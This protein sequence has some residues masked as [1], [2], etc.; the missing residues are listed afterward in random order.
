MAVVVNGDNDERRY[1]IRSK[2]ELFILV[3]FVNGMK[4]VDYVKR[5]TE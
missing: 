4:S 1:Y 2:A 3:A 5:E